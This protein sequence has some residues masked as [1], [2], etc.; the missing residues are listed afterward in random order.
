MLN[1]RKLLIHLI[2]LNH[3]ESKWSESVPDCHNWIGRPVL[4]YTHRWNSLFSF[5][6]LLLE[7]E[8]FWFR[9]RFLCLC[10]T[11]APGERGDLSGS[12]PDVVDDGILEPGYPEETRKKTRVFYLLTDDFLGS[13]VPQL[14]LLSALKQR[15]NKDILE[16][17]SRV[18]F[19]DFFLSFMTLNKLL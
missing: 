9:A 8:S 4:I 18:L 17:H 2:K 12:G 7:K 15:E 3:P 11:F 16:R 14:F 1:Y 10:L 6:Y 5:V 13:H 19:C